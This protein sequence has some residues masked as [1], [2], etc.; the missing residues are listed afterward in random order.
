M[1]ISSRSGRRSTRPVTAS[2]RTASPTSSSGRRWRARGRR[3]ASTSPR[4]GRGE[5]RRSQ[6]ALL[7]AWYGP[8]QEAFSTLK[9]VELED[10]VRAINRAEPGLIRVDADETTYSLH[11]ILRFELEQEMLEGTVA[12]VDLPEIWDTRMK[13][14]LGVDVPHVGDG[15]LQDVHWSG[16]GIGDFPSDAL[17]NVI[18]LQLWSVVRS[19]LPDLDAQLAAGDVSQ[20]SAW[21]RDNLYSLGRKLTPKE[22]LERLTGSP[23]LDP[24][25]YLGVSPRQDRDVT[26]GE[27]QGLLNVEDSAHSGALLDRYAEL[28]RAEMPQARRSSTRTPISATTS[29]GWSVIVTSSLKS[30]PD[31]ESSVRSSSASMSPIGTRVSRPRTSGRWPTR[32]PATARSFRS[33][34][35]TSMSLRSTRPHAVS[36]P[37]RRGSSSHPRAQ[38]FLPDDDRLEPVFALAADRAV[39]ILIHGGRGLPPIADGL[40][41]LLDKH[42]PPAL[43]IAHAGII[44]LAAM[45]RNFAGRP[46]CS[47]TR[48]CGARSISSTSTARFHRSRSCTPRTTRMDASRTRC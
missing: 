38:R 6:P 19:A 7:G 43:I 36:T 39:P 4:A 46:G 5:P 23:E 26:S 31:S 44:D 34:A 29:T 2:T 25:P 24:G 42:E 37:A 30:K 14:F 16:G 45:A 9:A 33:S 17:G 10:F 1:T 47:S 35:L 12:L 40:G 28:T 32:R 22:T 18:S 20:L 48:P 11:I 13:E 21:L 8:L 3:L 27:R 41:R 15:V